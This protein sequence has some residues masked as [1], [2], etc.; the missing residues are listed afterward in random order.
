MTKVQIEKRDPFLTL[1][2]SWEET[3]LYVGHV[4]QICLKVK[5]GVTNFLFESHCAMSIADEANEV[6]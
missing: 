4:A 1:S 2:L 3:L 5:S 6:Q